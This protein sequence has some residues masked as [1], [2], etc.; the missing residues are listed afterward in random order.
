MAPR[1]K[2]GDLGFILSMMGSHGWMRKGGD[3]ITFRIFMKCS[4]C[5]AKNVLSWGKSGP[6][7]AS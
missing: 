5:C 3:V 4:G 1:A 2:G 7:E 6:W